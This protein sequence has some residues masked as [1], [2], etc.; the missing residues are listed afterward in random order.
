MLLIEVVNLQAL[1]KCSDA[2]GFD[3]EEDA[4]RAHDIMALKC[5]GANSSTNFNQDNYRLLLPKL[6]KASK[7]H[8]SNQQLCSG[9]YECCRGVVD[10][11]PHFEQCRHACND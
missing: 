9:I 5:R 4:A 7:V 2:G 3:N 8:T 10:C 6:D 11:L 1:S